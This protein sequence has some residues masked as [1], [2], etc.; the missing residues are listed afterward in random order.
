MYTVNWKQYDE[1]WSALHD[2]CIGTDDP[3]RDAHAMHA[4]WSAA[5]CKNVGLSATIGG[6]RYAVSR[7][8]GAPAE[9]VVRE[10]LASLDPDEYR[11]LCGLLL[12]SRA[13]LR[14]WLRNEVVDALLHGPAAA[15]WDIT[16]APRRL[17]DAA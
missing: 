12:R 15:Y 9:D 2:P 1:L 17:A 4:W 5:L 14:P 16:P 6:L 7:S 8:R 3:A 13:V 11:S 10:V